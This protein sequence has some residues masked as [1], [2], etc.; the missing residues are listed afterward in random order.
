MLS[1]QKGIGK[2]ERLGLEAS[3]SKWALSDVGVGDASSMMN[4][5]EAT[6]GRFFMTDRC[7]MLRPETLQ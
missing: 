6:D 5:I 2:P 3:D 4:T 1:Q 7:L